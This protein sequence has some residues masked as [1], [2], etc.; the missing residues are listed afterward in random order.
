MI[1]TDYLSACIENLM[2]SFEL[3]G[4]QK[5]NDKLYLVYRSAVI[6]EFEL[7]LEQSGKL[8]KKAIEP[9]FANNEA[10]DKLFFKEIFKYAHKFGLMN[11]DEVKRW[12]EYRDSRNKT[13]HD[14]GQ[15]L[16]QKTLL[17][18]QD[19]LVDSKNLITIIKKINVADK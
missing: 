9:F 14:Y 2:L 19:F 11:A 8:L 1:N 7:I 15:D 5:N 3:M 17:L 12:F 10:V 4:Q 18:V 13:A 16:A 6:K